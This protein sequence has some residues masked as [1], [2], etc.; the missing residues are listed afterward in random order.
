MRIR[1]WLSAA[2]VAVAMVAL[3]GCSQDTTTT[4]TAPEP[5]EETPAVTQEVAPEPEMIAEAVLKPT[6]ESEG[7][8]GTVTFTETEG[9]VIIVAHLEGTP[10]GPH[11][12]HLHEIGDCSAS[13]FT[14]AGGHFNPAAVDHAGPHDEVRHAGDFGNIEVGADGSAHLELTSDLITLGEGDNSIMGRAVI[15][16]KDADD[17]TSQPTGAAGA[18]IACGVIGVPAPAAAA[19]D[20]GEEQASH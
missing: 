19:A 11:G 16:H 3:V 9:S 5:Q 6:A 8:S 7:M 12:F 2:T 17:L 18:R 13:D 14:S 4:E 15:V 10:S 20:A 1:H